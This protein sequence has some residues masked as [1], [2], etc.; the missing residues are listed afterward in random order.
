MKYLILT[1]LLLGLSGCGTNFG[2]GFS[3]VD[4]SKLKEVQ[5]VETKVGDSYAFFFKNDKTGEE[6]KVPATKEEYEDISQNDKQPTKRGYTFTWGY[7]GKPI[8]EN[9]TPTLEN[10]EYVILEKETTTTPTTILIK[11]ND[12]ETIITK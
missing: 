3:S 12:K 11:I 5:M 7:G 8:I 1:I 6:I 2:A 9:V 4:L 10:G